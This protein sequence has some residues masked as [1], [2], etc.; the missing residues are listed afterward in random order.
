MDWLDGLA[1][2]PEKVRYKEPEKHAHANRPD[3]EHKTPIR[4]TRVVQEA[5]MEMP[6]RCPA[7]V[8]KEYGDGIP[9]P[10]HRDEP[11]GGREIDS[12]PLELGEQAEVLCKQRCCAGEM[13]NCSE[14]K[15]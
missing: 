12:G 2:P 9:N 14:S 13:N 8:L 7:Q 11:Y 1:S 15:R 10:P 4:M 5:P 6:A 3:E